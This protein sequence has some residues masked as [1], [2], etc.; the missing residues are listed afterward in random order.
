MSPGPG[1]P[2]RTIDISLTPIRDETGKVLCIEPEGRES[3]CAPSSHHDPL[4]HENGGGSH[5][6]HRPNSVHPGRAYQRTRRPADAVCDVWSELNDA[7]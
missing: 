5:G 2:A 3:T 4:G 1:E 7:S 6:P